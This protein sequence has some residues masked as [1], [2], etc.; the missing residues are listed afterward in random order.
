MAGAAMRA[1]AEVPLGAGRVMGSIILPA[2]AKE[3]RAVR[4]SGWVGE[5]VWVGVGE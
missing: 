5:R 4:E 3:S 1:W 2:C